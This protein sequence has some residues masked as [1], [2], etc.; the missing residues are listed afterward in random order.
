MAELVY[1][2]V[3][4]TSTERFKSSSL[5]LPTNT[6]RRFIVCTSV[7]IHATYATFVAQPCTGAYN[8]I[9]EKTIYLPIFGVIL[10]YLFLNEEITSKVIISLIAVIIGIYIVK[11]GSKIKLV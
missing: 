3:L 4:G 1:A 2:L 10:G 11:K 6:S 8:L 9:N 5:F 7:G